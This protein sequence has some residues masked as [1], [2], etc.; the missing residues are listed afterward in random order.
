MKNQTRNILITALAILMFSAVACTSAE[1][2]A[3]VEPAVFVAQDEIVVEEQPHLA[4][5]TNTSSGLTEAE[6]KGLLFMREEEKLAGDVYRYL[7]DQWGSAIFSNIA[8]SED[9]HTESVLALINAYG[10]NDPAKVEVGQFSDLDLQALYDQLTAQGSQSL[11]D[12]YMVGAAIEEI[13]ILDLDAHIAETDRSD[14]IF[15][16]ENLKSGSENHLRAFVRV[17]Q[18]QLREDYSPQYMTQEQYTD[19][20]A[21]ENSTGNGI[22]GQGEGQGYGKGKP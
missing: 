14:I 18:N 15:V 13:D 11:Q 7:F 1:E 22:G 12:A 21:G 19:I 5:Q 17:Y 3:Q 16:Y 6:V 2:S 4:E 9:A 20:I 8:Q 10:I